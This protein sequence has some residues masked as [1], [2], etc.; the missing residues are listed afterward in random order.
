MRSRGLGTALLLA[1]ITTAWECSEAVYVRVRQGRGRCFSEDV[2]AH[3]PL[4]ITYKSP[5][6]APLPTQPN[7]LRH[8][9][10]V[11]LQITNYAGQILDHRLDQEGR[12]SFTTPF[13]AEHRICFVVRG[14]SLGQDFRVHVAIDHALTHPDDVLRR[15]ALTNIDQRVLA[16]S[17]TIERIKTEQAYFRERENRFFLTTASTNARAQWC[18]VAQLFV[19]LFQAAISIA[20][21]RYYFI[22]QNVV[23][24]P[25]VTSTNEDLDMEVPGA[26]L[27]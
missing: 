11:F 18:T 24:R 25:T 17:D 8:H 2:Q 3:V 10:G 15:E 22:A 16:L 26:L 13:D 19:W 21:V 23:A 12:K 20:C 7:A 4:V 6:Q 14:H 1:M 9:V 27:G 5:D